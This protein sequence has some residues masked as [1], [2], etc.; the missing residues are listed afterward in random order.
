M[1]TTAQASVA[2]PPTGW[3]RIAPHLIY[4]DPAAAIGWLTRSFGFTERT[5]A[6]HSS[7]AGTVERAQ[8]QVGDSVLTLGLPSIH[9]ES[10]R[11]GV[12]TMLTVYV[13]DVD[14]HY[15]RATAAG[16]T[17]V[18]ELANQPWGDRRYQASDPEGH[19]WSF[20]QHI[21]D[22]APGACTSQPHH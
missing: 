14:A 6:R 13:D 9:G 2:N 1:S 10:P 5:S 22:V 7:P 8:M 15:Q 17:I 18:L 12:S 16:A 4:E 3:P 11:R 20:A 21:F 19:Q